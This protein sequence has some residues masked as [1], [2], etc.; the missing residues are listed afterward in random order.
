MS[1]YSFIVD[2]IL[3]MNVKLESVIRG[4]NSGIQ[5]SRR[6]LRA[7]RS[8]SALSSGGVFISRIAGPSEPSNAVSDAESVC[9]ESAIKYLA[10]NV[11]ASGANAS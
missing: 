5:D 8:V 4:E 11:A 2:H 6:I 10:P 3:I 1:V 9:G 7:S